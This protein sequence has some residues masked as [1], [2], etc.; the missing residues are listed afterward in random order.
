MAGVAQAAG[1]VSAACGGI[2]TFT[3][4]SAEANVV[5]ISLSA[6]VYTVVDTGAQISAAAGCTNVNPNEATC[7]AAGVTALVVDLGDGND[8]VTI[9]ATTGSNIKGGPGDDTLKGGK[10]PD[11]MDGGPGADIFD[12]GAGIDTVTYSSR[13]SPIKATI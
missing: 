9:S 5:T 8:A 7:A 10:G 12:G 4:G 11:L 1:T 2:L 3:A 13:T 6:N